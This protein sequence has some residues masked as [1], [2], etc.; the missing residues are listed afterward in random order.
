MNAAPASHPRA[1]EPAAHSRAARTLRGLWRVADPK[2]TLASMSS[3]LLGLAF[4]WRD[5]SV[6]WGWLG[7]TVAGLFFVE[8]AK[9]ASGEVF[10]LEA[11]RAVRPEHRSPFSGGKRVIVDGLMGARATLAMAASFYVAAA[12][13]GAGIVFGREPAVLGLGA[14][15]LALA[16]SYNGPPLRLAY[17]GLGELA[18]AAVY[19][20]LISSGVYLV[21]R[22]T[23]A[24][25]LIAASVPLALL[26]AGFLW[27]NEVPD[28]AADRQAGKRNLV[29]RLGLRR[30]SRAFAALMAVAYGSLV[31]VAA[32]ASSWW[33]L[34]GLAGAPWAARAAARLWRGH[35]SVAAVIPAQAWTLLSFCLYAAGAAGG[36]VASVWLAH[37]SR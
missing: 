24:F 37:V 7:L 33:L 27:I 32:T 5:G 23:V 18:V 30:A 20:P 12:L 16:F 31:V 21:Q 36:V 28:Y 22:G 11:D 1:A 29:V 19:G 4:A 3:A 34:G 17:H 25:E 35:D 14:V 15:G 9:N 2:I 8:A 6:S 26:I 10:D 13:V